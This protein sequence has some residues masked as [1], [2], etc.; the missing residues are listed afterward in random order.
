MARRLT[1]CAALW[2]CA[3]VIADVPPPGSG[4]PNRLRTD[5]VL[6]AVVLG[7]GLFALGAGAVY[8]VWRRRRAAASTDAPPRP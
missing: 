5:R 4:E 7:A 8:V 1:L 3:P 6:L 2:A